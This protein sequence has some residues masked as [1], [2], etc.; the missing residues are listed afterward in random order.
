MKEVAL[1]GCSIL[2]FH[3]SYNLAFMVRVIISCHFF[4]LEFYRSKKAK[5]KQN[6][7]SNMYK[8]LNS[9]YYKKIK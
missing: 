7:T 3:L 9:W 1:L 2:A 5:A 4:S 8:S 6:K